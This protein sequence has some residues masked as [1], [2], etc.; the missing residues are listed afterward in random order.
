MAVTNG[1][2]Q[3][4]IPMRFQ[5]TLRQSVTS[6]RS[7]E[8]FRNPAAPQADQPLADTGLTGLWIAALGASFLSSGWL[9]VSK[10]RTKKDAKKGPGHGTS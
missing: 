3:K 8:E 2:Q 4:V 9:A 5:V 6:Q 1:M 10:S 7:E